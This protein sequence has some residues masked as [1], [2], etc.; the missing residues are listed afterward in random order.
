[1]FA[2][3]A[4]MMGNG[5]GNGGIVTQ[6]VVQL[7][8]MAAGEVGVAGVNRAGPA[9]RTVAIPA[10][11]YILIEMVWAYLHS[12]L[13]ILGMDGLGLVDLAPAGSALTQLGAVASL[14]LGPTVVALL[15]EL[16]RYLGKVRAAQQT[17]E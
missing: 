2:R 9:I 1:M 3:L 17:G 6:T 13:G 16:Y 7:P 10:W 14:A 8:G 11:R 4:R 15:N 5:T 12:F